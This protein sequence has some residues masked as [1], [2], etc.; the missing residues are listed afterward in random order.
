VLSGVLVGGVTEAVVNCGIGGFQVSLVNQFAPFGSW[1]RGYKKLPAPAF[2]QE[3][4][5]DISRVIGCQL[6]GPGD[7]ADHLGRPV[8]SCQTKQATQ[9][10]ARLHELAVQAEVELTSLEAEGIKHLFQGR[11]PRPLA[12][13]QRC[14]EV[15][16]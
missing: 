12:Y 11:A 4:V 5:L 1:Q 14:C 2:R 8:D 9:V 15:F 13:S 6:Q 16:R 7:G 10:N 3:K